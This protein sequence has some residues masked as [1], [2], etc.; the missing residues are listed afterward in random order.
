[1]GFSSGKSQSSSWPVD[2]T[3]EAFKRLQLPFATVLA[4]ML[5]YN[6]RDEGGN[7]GGGTGPGESGT[8]SGGGYWQTSPFTLGKNSDRA[9]AI[10][11]RNAE[12]DAIFKDN[13]AFD[14]RNNQGYYDTIMGSRPDAFEF[15]YGGQ[16]AGGGLPFGF[17]GSGS[18][19]YDHGLFF[20]EYGDPNDLLRGIP[21]YDDKLVADLTDEERAILEKLRGQG[22]VDDVRDYLQRVMAGDFVRDAQYNPDNIN[23]FLNAAIEAAQRPTLEGLEETLSRTLPG[24]FTAAGHFMQ[25][26]GS[27][28]FDRAAAIATRGASNAMADIATNLS[29]QTTEAEMDRHFQGRENDLARQ[30]ASSQ[31]LVDLSREEMD[32]TLKNLQA[33]ALPRLIEEYGIERGIQEFQNRMGNFMILIQTLAGVTHPVIA[34]ASQGSSKQTGVSLK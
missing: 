10:A 3:P 31:G 12:L 30:F 13:G 23:P 28:A 7:G 20:D 17:G 6:V 19:G 33:Q 18:G 11:D 22:N 8:S 1:M 25:P 9:K 32:M 15:G 2:M 14:P 26:Q 24:R 27:S 4:R 29:Y 21:G 5:G 16:F 34:Q